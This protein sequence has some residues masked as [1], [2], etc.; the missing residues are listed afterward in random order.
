MTTKKDKPCLWWLYSVACFAALTLTQTAFADDHGGSGHLSDVAFSA[1]AGWQS[2]YVD[3]EEGRE[4]EAFAGEG[5]FTTE[6]VAEY[7][8]FFAGVWSGQSD[9]ANANETNFSIGKEIEWDIEWGEDSEG[10]IELEVAYTY[11]TFGGKAA[12]EDGH[13]GHELEVE[14]ACE[15]CLP[16]DMTAALEV[17][18]DLEENG[19]ASVFALSR[20]IHADDITITPYALVALDNDFVTEEYDGVNHY[21][22]GMEMFMPVTRS[23]YVTVHA[24]HVFAGEDIRRQRR[25]ELAEAAEARAA[26]EVGE[27]EEAEEE[28]AN[29]DDKSWVGINLEYAF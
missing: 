20:E 7:N 16:M 26:G 24:G 25:D 14:L 23:L 27:A 28:A 9:G 18:Y 3:D 6:F 29:L 22:V 10:E 8:G 12:E 15:E 11:L 21:Q 5:L 2:K 19:H 4:E 1:S 13:D 17:T